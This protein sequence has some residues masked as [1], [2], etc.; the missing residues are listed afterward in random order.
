MGAIGRFKMT[1]WLAALCAIAMVGC[2]GDTDPP[3]GDGGLD[4]TVTADAGSDG[5][6]VTLC[7]SDTE[8][9]NSDFCDGV[10]RCMPGAMG[11]GADGCVPGEAPCATGETCDEAAD[12]CTPDDCVDEDGDG[13]T[14]CEGDCD[15]SRADI[16]PSQE[17]FCAPDN[18]TDE[19]CNPRTYGFVDI[20]MDGAADARC[21][22]EDADG[23][24][25]GGTDC[26]DNNASVSPLAAEVCDGR[27][28][29][30]CDGTVDEDCLC[31][32][33][34]ST[35]SCGSGLGECAGA[36][37]TCSATGWSA[38]SV[39]PTAELCDGSRDE[40]CDGTVDEG[41]G[42]VTGTTRSCG[43]GAC[44]G[45]Q[46]C[47]AGAWTECDGASPTT[48]TCDGVDTDCDGIGDADDTDVVGAGDL[49]G[50]DTGACVAG[51]MTCLGSTLSCVGEVSARAEVC[52]GSL[53]E[54][55]DGTVDEGCECVN[56]TVQS[57]GRGVCAGQRSCSA[58][59]WSGCLRPDGSPAPLPG[60]ITETCDGTDQDC[61]G[62]DDAS[63]PDVVGAGDACGSDVGECVA[64][65]QTCLGSVLSC[66]GEVGPTTEICDARDNDCDGMVDGGMCDCVNGTVR[67]CGTG[68]CAGNQTCVDGRWAGCSGG[69]P[70]TEICNGRDDDCDGSTDNVSGIGST[71]GTNT[72][73]C[74]AGT[75]MCDTTAMTLECGGGYVASSPEMCNHLDDDCDGSRD[76]GVGLASRCTRTFTRYEGYPTSLSPRDL[77]RIAPSPAAAYAQGWAGDFGRSSFYRAQFAV[78]GTSDANWATT[79]VL[80]PQAGISAGSGCGTYCTAVG[81]PT[82]ASGEQAIAV[83]IYGG[84]VLS[85]LS[86]NASGWSSV[87]AGAIAP[88]CVLDP[89][90]VMTFDIEL[91]NNRGQFQATMRGDGCG[92][93]TVTWNSEP[94][95]TALYGERADFDR[96]NFG[97]VGYPGTSGVDIR[98]TSLYADRRTSRGANE[99]CI[100]CF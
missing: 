86:G 41:C 1:R 12:V 11:A 91:T 56:G 7:A 13:F 58:G 66:V 79:M 39:T 100:G 35:R 61:D 8:C 89:G 88:G 9:S 96:Y 36:V 45:I 33:E 5:G 21:Y 22:N 24:R 95:W 49:C 44:A 38:C 47:V 19:D 27:F 52:D 54:D 15:D 3:E 50:T 51:R 10:E 82:L 90:E 69:A 84:A 68:E 17:E 32:P 20:D 64:G 62:I 18:P 78:V 80:S 28:D 71:C 85:V 6:S 70:T 48:E 72:G 53:D 16:N 34:G 76:E 4:A 97:A 29:E 37:E 81:L 98:V 77:S 75:L 92:F 46:E 30:N 42:C 73:E 74:S 99:N 60:T 83:Q 67:T 94:T 2:G 55:C 65:V 40:N 59:R 57:C 23:T 26:D 87:A 25:Y 31:A 43:R 63:D 93:T 14:T